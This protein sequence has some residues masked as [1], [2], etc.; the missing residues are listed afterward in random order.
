MLRILNPWIVADMLHNREGKTYT[1][2]L[3]VTNG[4]QMAVI[5][6]GRKDTSLVERI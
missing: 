5:T 4:T 1:I 2:K 6:E 3:P